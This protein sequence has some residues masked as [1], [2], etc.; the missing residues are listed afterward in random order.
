MKKSKQLKKK[1]TMG[2]T[3]GNYTNKQT[4]KSP[5][6]MLLRYLDSQRPIFFFIIKCRFAVDMVTC[7]PPDDFFQ[8]LCEAALTIS[9]TEAGQTELFSVGHKKV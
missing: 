7:V 2:S 4:K 5:A 3:K 1:S 8:E 6:E 9:Q